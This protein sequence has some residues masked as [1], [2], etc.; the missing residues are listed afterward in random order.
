MAQ[1]LPARSS[2]R[3]AH[4]ANANVNPI[5]DHYQKC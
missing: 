4:P 5:V 2:W 1:Q 3:L